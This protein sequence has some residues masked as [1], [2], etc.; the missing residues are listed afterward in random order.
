M[1]SRHHPTAFACDRGRRAL[2]VGGGAGILWTLLGKSALG[3]SGATLRALPDAVSRGLQVWDPH[4]EGYLAEEYLLAGR[5]HV[6][7][8]VS[9]ADA[10]DTA[11]RDNAAD[12][13]PR[14]R[15]ARRIVQ[16]RVP[17]TTRLILYRP[18][19]SARASGRAIVEPVHP[20][21]G[22]Q[23]IVWRSLTPFFM[24]QGD[25][26]VAVQH[27]TTFPG[28]H[29]ADPDR[30]GPLSAAHPSQRWG[31]LAD[32]GRLLK[33][34]ALAG[35]ER[36]HLYMTGYSFTGVATSTFANYH[37]DDTR[38]ADGAP[39]FDGYAPCANAMYVRPLDVPVLRMNTESDFN[40]FDGIHH[41]GHDS[42]DAGA[43]YRL[44]ELAGAAHVTTPWPQTHAALPPRDVR[45]AE[46]KGLPSFSGEAC[47]AQF[48]A[49]SRPNDFPTHLLQA[50]VMRNLYDWVEHGRAP[51][52]G[53]LLETDTRGVV[54]RDVLG[55]A[56]GGVRVT[57][58]AVPI[59]RYG[60]GTGAQC[61]LF[62]FT[63]PFRI[64]QKRRLHGSRDAYLVKSRR[65]ADELAAVRLLLPEGRDE[66]IAWAEKSEPF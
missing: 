35:L 8:P 13:A 26:Y 15:Y 3:A 60:V 40:S 18:R 22:G 54:K 28:L 49:G 43:R 58:I 57:P 47:Q 21:G 42:D 44:Y 33:S 24:R 45:V 63:Q 64:E 25:T 17:Y 34:G 41:R 51:P 14:E 37:H 12:Q 52:P 9:M 31:M 46:G 16:Q 53:A 61:F 11:T 65:S 55:N 6:Y 20:G 66:L 10:I 2:L 59:A 27:P 7:E 32:T 19:D 29:R 48:P 62:G 36:P 56:L 5:A 4:A 38:L 39:V 30:Y 1:R 50:A 23:A